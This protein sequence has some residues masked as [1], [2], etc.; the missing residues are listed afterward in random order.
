MLSGASRLG[1][2]VVLVGGILVALQPVLVAEGGPSE[3]L[4]PHLVYD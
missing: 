1:G 2:V 4:V 3:G